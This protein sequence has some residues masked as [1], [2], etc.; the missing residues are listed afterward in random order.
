MGGQSLTLSE[1]VHSVDFEWV[2]IRQQ[3][4]FASRPNFTNFF[5]Q[6]AVVDHLL[7]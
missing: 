5:V 3:N 6:Q 2:G 4:F 7:F 1:I